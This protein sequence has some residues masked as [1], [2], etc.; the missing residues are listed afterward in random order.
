M[1]S[2]IEPMKVRPRPGYYEV[3]CIGGSR[4]GCQITPPWSQSG[5]SKGRTLPRQYVTY[6]LFK[7]AMFLAI[8]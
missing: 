1:T 7:Y 6:A 2:S 5:A 8:I 3:E 4:R